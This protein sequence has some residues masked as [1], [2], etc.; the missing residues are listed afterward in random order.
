MPDADVQIVMGWVACFLAFR[1]EASSNLRPTLAFNPM[2]SP[3]KISV[4]IADAEPA[5]RHGLI[6]LCNAHERLRVVG[7]SGSVGM[8]RELCQRLHPDL[9]IVDPAIDG[10]EGLALI[11]ELPRLARRTR[12]VAFARQTDAGHIEQALR[13][14]A[15]GYATR[16]EEESELMKVMLA[17]EDG[18]S[19]LSPRAMEAITHGLSNG[20]VRVSGGALARLS[21]RERQVFALLGA[22]MATRDV[23][24]TCGVSIKTAESHLEHIKV[25]LHLK[26]GTELRKAAADAVRE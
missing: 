19:H 5:S 26:S 11:K 14:G 21:M 4:V 23:A 18:K 16:Q 15:L 25:K 9:L 7:D 6:S 17:M 3:K 1:R 20:V 24:A 13:A 10:G 8:A 12:A 22:G 2:P